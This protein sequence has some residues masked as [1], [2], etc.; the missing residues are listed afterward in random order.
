MDSEG[1]ATDEG[2][3]VFVTDYYRT[4]QPSDLFFTNIVAKLAE[5]DK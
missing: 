4:L 3:K 5:D 2:V 1:I